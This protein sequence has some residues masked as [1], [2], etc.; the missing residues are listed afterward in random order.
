MP[1]SRRLA[2]A[3]A[4]TG[5]IAGPLLLCA[6]A[7]VDP[8][9]TDDSAAYLREVAAAEGRYAAAGVLSTVGALLMVAGTLA[10]ARLMRGRRVTLGQL[11][12]S[13]L[14][15]GLIGMSAGMAFNGFDIALAGFDDRQA[16]VA[17]YEEL[18]DSVLLNLFWMLFFFVG[19]VL[20]SLLLAIALFRRRIVPIW[21][22]L[23]LVAAIVLGFASGPNR[24]LTAL[25]FLVL[26]AGL[27]P[28]AL[29]IRSLADDQWE[30]WSP[31]GDQ[32]AREPDPGAAPSPATATVA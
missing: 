16:A 21:S 15:V 12:A 17:L 6:G 7:L 32:P 18:E 13:L 23:L 10:V 1:D 26:A 14:A 20:G 5:L 24:I 22:P 11:G 4:V 19:V 9:W 29:R 27:I 25:S 28:L 30:R 2:R 3:L 31:L 8:A